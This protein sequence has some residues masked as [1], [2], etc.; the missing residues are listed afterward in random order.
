MSKAFETERT[1][2]WR[3]SELS[4]EDE[5]TISHVETYGCSII[6]I[7]KNSAGPGWSFTLGVF[8]TTGKPEIIVV[9]LKHDSEENSNED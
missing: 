6:H 4:S 7:D 5:R 1:R 8:D 9:G 2:K 3:E